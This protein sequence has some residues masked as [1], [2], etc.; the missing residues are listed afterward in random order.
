M[1]TI[2]KT[3]TGVDVNAGIF[4]IYNTQLVRCSWMMELVRRGDW[5]LL[6]REEIELMEMIDQLAV[7]EEQQE[8]CD[9]MK[10]LRLDLLKEL[11]TNIDEIQDSLKSRKADLLRTTK[12]LSVDN[13]FFLDAKNSP[14]QTAETQ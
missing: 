14:G 7:F 3:N 12:P 11:F 5:D 10:S 13:V 2:T 6:V 4:S 9:D 1:S 8:F